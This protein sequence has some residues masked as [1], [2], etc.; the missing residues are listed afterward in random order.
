MNLYSSLSGE[1]RCG[2]IL[3]Q[4]DCMWDMAAMPVDDVHTYIHT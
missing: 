2:K 4:S 3:Y 1:V